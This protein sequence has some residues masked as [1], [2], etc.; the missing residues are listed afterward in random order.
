MFTYQLPYSL[1]NFQDMIQLE[2]C[3]EE[4]GKGNMGHMFISLFVT[5]FLYPPA[6]WL[7]LTLLCRGLGEC[8]HASHELIKLG[9]KRHLTQL[10]G[11]GVVVVDALLRTTLEGKRRR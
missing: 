2:F 11:A 8:L 3:V 9:D 1:P 5:P 7:L 10:H 6:V 4:R